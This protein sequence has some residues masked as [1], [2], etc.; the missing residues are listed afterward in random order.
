MRARRAQRR[1][2]SAANAATTTTAADA[3]ADAAA[4]DA[5]GRGRACTA[6]GTQVKGGDASEGSLGREEP[7]GLEAALELIGV[8]GRAGVRVGVRVRARVRVRV[9]VRLTVLRREDGEYIS[10]YL[11]RSPYISP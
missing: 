5:A 4:A 3:A 7:D 2:R 9:R 11:P 1:R 8:R 6:R 10:L